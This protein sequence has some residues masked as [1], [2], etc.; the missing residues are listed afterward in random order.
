[1]AALSIGVVLV[2]AATWAP[3]LAL[4]L[5]GGMIA[6]AGAGLLFKGA[7]VT[8]SGLAAPERR[9]EVLAGFFLAGYVGISVPVL[10]LGILG[11]LIEPKVA[12]L[13]FAALLLAAIAASA[14]TLLG[15][16]RAGNLQPV[17]VT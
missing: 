3:S 5:A 1:M 11:Q 10:G 7:I 8:A 16:G 15:G 4:F 9:A 14:R 6:G 17:A 12:L 2:V 13:A